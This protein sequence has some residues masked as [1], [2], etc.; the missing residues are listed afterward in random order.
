V[1]AV[2]EPMRGGPRLRCPSCRQLTRAVVSFHEHVEVLTG[3]KGAI[4]TRSEDLL[5][6]R[7]GWCGNLLEP[8]RPV[9]IAD[10]DPL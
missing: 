3:P 2:E 5:E 1:G 10:V 8:P 9:V 4:S 6:R 7:C